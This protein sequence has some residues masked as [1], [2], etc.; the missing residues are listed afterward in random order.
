MAGL[1]ARDEETVPAAEP[2]QP[3]VG[4]HERRVVRD[5]I[6]EQEVAL[7]DTAT[8]AD[9]ESVALEAAGGHRGRLSLL[10]DRQVAT[11]WSGT[12]RAGVGHVVEQEATVRP[13]KPM[14]AGAQPQ[15]ACVLEIAGLPHAIVVLPRREALTRVST[16]DEDL[17]DVVVIAGV[18]LHPQKS[19][20]L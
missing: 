7:A 14:H 6:A 4:A 13:A 18:E 1:E 5:V 19:L 3:A 20:D 16:V 8:V 17:H 15:V 2:K 10:F 9:G 11:L 12:V